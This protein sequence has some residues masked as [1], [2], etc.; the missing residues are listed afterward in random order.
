MLVCHCWNVRD[1]EIRRAVREGAES[2]RAIRRTSRA[3]S[4]CGG[5]R[6]EV[7]RIIESERERIRARSLP[8]AEFEPA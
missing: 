6:R 2:L 3:G 7:T 4:G 1:R 5:C 8:L